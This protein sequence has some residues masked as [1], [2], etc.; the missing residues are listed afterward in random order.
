MYEANEMSEMSI[1]VAKVTTKFNAEKY[2]LENESKCDASKYHVFTI[3]DATKLFGSRDIYLW[4][5]GQKGRGFYLALQRCG[6]EIKGFLDS[7]EQMVGTFYRGVP[8]MHPD[9]I[10][11]ISDAKNKIFV[12]TASVDSKN[13]EMFSVLESHGLE[14]GH[15]FESIQTLSPFY[16][17]VEVAGLCNLKCSSCPRSDETM[18]ETGKYMSADDYKLVIEKMVKEIPFLYLVDLYIF[19]EPL[20]NKDL[21][22]IIK[23]NNELGLASGLSTNLNNIR[24]LDAVLEEFPAQ[25]RVSLS[26]ASKETYEV[27]HTGGRWDRVQKNLEKLGELHKKYNYR[28]IIEVYFHIYKHN[29]KEI[30]E[31]KNI[32]DK[33]G[34]RFHPSLAVLF[35]DYAM[36]H[37]ENGAV[38]D[39]ATAANE[40]TILDLETLLND[41]K[42]QDKLNCILTRIVPVINWD[43]SVM[44]CCNYSYSGIAK[45]YLETPL[46]EIINKRTYSE[47]CGKCQKYSLHRWNNQIYYSGLV[48]DL[49]E[50]NSAT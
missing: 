31:I 47:T 11:K 46:S 3:A 8:V 10:L 40:L 23:I 50:Q 37:A 41:C 2:F 42:E 12:L 38:P 33:Y 27:T 18:M 45:N 7:N 39:V 17:T 29:L 26:G 48:N 6:F 13:K 22:K 21:P 9:S 34:F 49:V 16:P 4:G 20:L 14:K 24:N 1:N 19:G 30:G 5:G 44:P 35:S 32:C 43:L 36:A 28:T 15:Q 25:L